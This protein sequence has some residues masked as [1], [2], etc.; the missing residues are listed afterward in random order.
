MPV[1]RNTTNVRGGGSPVDGAVGASPFL[2]WAGGKRW[3]CS[4]LHDFLPVRF[5]RYFEPFLGSAA[6]FFHLAPT[7]AY[8]SDTNAELINVYTKVRDNLPEVI[9][10]LA[11][12]RVNKRTYL[13]IRKEVPSDEVQRAARLIYLNKTAFNGLYRV[14]R[15]GGFNV[16]FAGM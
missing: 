8:L 9:D 2:K 15:Q 12:L 10:A 14:N 6:V 4:S 5:N 11:E 1:V 7:C 13:S 3:L 16:P